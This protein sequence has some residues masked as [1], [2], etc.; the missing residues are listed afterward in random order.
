MNVKELMTSDPA[1]CTKETSLQDVA[2]LMVRCDCGEIPVV[3]GDN[4]KRPVGV[5]TDRDIVCRAVA[6]GRDPA[7]MRAGDV[8]T[9][10]AVCAK[11]TDDVGAVER[12]M[13]THQIRRVPVINQSGEIC[14]IVSVADV[15]RRDSRKDT[16]Q[17][18][19]EV[20]APSR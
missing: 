13:A 12:L 8:M 9:S 10:P 14:G 6:E 3:E 4:R 16:G 5:V 2:R 17:V 1:C 7:S 11:E 15:A 18:V 20:S 19:R